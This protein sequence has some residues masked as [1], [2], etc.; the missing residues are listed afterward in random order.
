MPQHP[1]ALAVVLRNIKS[2]FSKGDPISRMHPVDPST[3]FG[4]PFEDVRELSGAG[5]AEF[6]RRVSYRAPWFKTFTPR[7]YQLNRD[8]LVKHGRLVRLAEALATLYISK[9]TTIP[10]PHIFDVFT[11]SGSTYIVQE[12][13][14]APTLA[15][16]WEQLSTKEKKKSV[17][18]LAG[19]IDQLR[20]LPPPEKSG[21]VQAIDGGPCMD[22]KVHPG[23]WGP[24][25]THYDF[26]EFRHHARVRTYPDDY[27][28]A[29]IS[30]SRIKNKSWRTV[31]AHGDLCPHNILWKDGKIAAIVDWGRAGWF[32]EYWDYAR[33]S[34][35]TNIDEWWELLQ[36]HVHQ[37]P[38]ELEVEDWLAS[39]SAHR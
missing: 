36:D 29:Q 23:E 11:I 16:V 10:V 33:A 7:V 12:Y 15:S 38:D 21:K 5:L 18:Q 24:F 20:A 19:I 22:P 9:N 14:D 4:I 17:I 26:S 31:F 27:M 3:E 28:E 8:Q 39:R 32:P 2:E 1:S 25:D 34:L 35:G 13:I 6:Q 37:Y 30:L